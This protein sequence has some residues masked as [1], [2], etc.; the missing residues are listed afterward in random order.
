MQDTDGRRG[1]Y[2]GVEFTARV[3]IEV[4][5]SEPAEKTSGPALKLTLGLRDVPAGDFATRVEPGEGF[6][7]PPVF[8]GCYWGN[9]DDG[10]RSIAAWVA[11]HVAG[12][13]RSSVSAPGEQFVG[14]WDGR[15]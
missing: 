3:G 1:I 6:L 2:A 4:Q 8:I 9:V 5:A 13:A 12:G 11:R 15:R 14:Q 10:A 7:V